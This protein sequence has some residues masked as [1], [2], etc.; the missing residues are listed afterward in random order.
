MKVHFAIKQFVQICSERIQNLIKK[1][2]LLKGYN[3]LIVDLNIPILNFSWE[4]V[5]INCSMLPLN[6]VLA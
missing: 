5:I 4:T 1:Y 6:K 3:L 2:P